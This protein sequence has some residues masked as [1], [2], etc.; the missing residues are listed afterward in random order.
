MQ[1]KELFFSSFGKPE[2]N[3]RGLVGF[4]NYYFIWECES[5]NGLVFLL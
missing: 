2:I 3:H 5:E 4:S 1:A